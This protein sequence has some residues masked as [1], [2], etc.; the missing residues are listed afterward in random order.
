MRYTSLAE[1]KMKQTESE[2]LKPLISRDA[3]AE[4]SLVA[5]R[6]SSRYPIPGKLNLA[7]SAAQ[8]AAAFAV[9]YVAS[10]AAGNLARCC[11]AVLF[12]F[13]MQQGFCLAHEAVHGKLQRR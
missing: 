9:L 4:G 12:A 8:R 13:V 5:R 11:L 6:D 7:L 3:M 10:R 2:N 1:G